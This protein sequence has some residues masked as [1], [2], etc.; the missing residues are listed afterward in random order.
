MCLS[1][2]RWP[3]TKHSEHGGKWMPASL[4]PVTA[5]R[6]GSRSGVL[7]GASIVHRPLDLGFKIGSRQGAEYLKAP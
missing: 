7:N 2:H 1:L 3:N 4:A 6:P 5:S